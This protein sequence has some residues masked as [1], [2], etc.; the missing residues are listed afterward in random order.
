MKIEVCTTNAKKIVCDTLIIG[1]WE[2]TVLTRKIAE[3]HGEVL[4]DHIAHV[5]HRQP[6]CGMYGKTINIYPVEAIGE[7]RIMLLG[8]G[9]PRELTVDKIRDV[10][11]IAARKIRKLEPT[12]VSCILADLIPSQIEPEGMVKAIVEGIILG[13]YRFNYYKTTKV[14]AEIAKLFII[15]Q[16]ENTAMLQKA[17]QRGYIIS[18]SVNL[19]RDLS[20]HPS[21]NM[22][23][24]KMAEHAVEIAR[25]TGMKLVILSAADMAKQQMN[26]ISAVAQGSDEPP[27]LIV[28]RYQGDTSCKEI[29]AFVG[30]GVTFDSGGISLKPS[31]K[32]G[33]M[34]GDMAGGAAVLGAMLAIGR[35]KPKLNV[36]AVV[37]CVENMP[38]GHALKPGDIIKTMCG[39]TVEI[40]TTD[41]EGRLILADGIT[42]ARTAGATR[43]VDVATLTGACAVALGNAASGVISNDQVWCKQILQAAETAGEKMWELPHY[44]EYTE[45]IKSEI[46]DL[47]NSGGRMAGAITAGMFLAQFADELPWVH[48]D[49]AGTADIDK[50]R[51]CNG[52]GAT[53][54][55]LRTLVQL[56]EDIGAE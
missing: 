39:K 26:A 13:A 37:P 2:E 18:Q 27:C 17:A 15:V 33:E 7:K 14:D 10:F 12:T 48:I 9:K 21:R 22:T 4:A 55:G 16:Q 25:Q 30:K 11:A 29:V 41:A 47:K 19:A 43:I 40:I 52:K 50:A 45:Q 6:D 53:G 5:I 46:A 23:P 34:K 8:L 31:D 1:V 54:A 42:Y 3:I 35:L 49:I 56:A 36:I 51:G 28:L 24:T 32:M 38:S 20:N 44:P